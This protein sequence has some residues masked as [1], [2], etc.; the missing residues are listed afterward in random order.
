MAELL[1][2]LWTAMEDF[3]LQCAGVDT[4]ARRSL[5][6]HLQLMWD[7]SI[8]WDALTSNMESKRVKVKNLV[9]QDQKE[10]QTSLLTSESS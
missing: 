5:C 8:I 7:S 10:Y 4:T 3:P 2:T 9:Q 6:D 1:T